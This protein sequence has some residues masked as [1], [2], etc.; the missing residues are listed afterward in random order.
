MLIRLREISKNFGAVQALKGVSLDLH[1]GEILAVVGENGA[2]KSTLMKILGG[3]YPHGDFQGQIEND[4][5]SFQFKSPRDSEAAGIAFIHQELSNFPD[6]TV[7]EN[8]VVGHWPAQAGFVKNDQIYQYADTWLQKLGAEFSSRQKMSELSTGQQQ[9]VEIAKALSRNSKIL[10]LDEPTSSLTSRETVKLFALLKELRGQGC[11]LIY[12]SHRMEEIFALADRVAI[13]RDGQSVFTAS[14]KELDEQKIVHHMVGRNLEHFFPERTEPVPSKV[15]LRIENFKARHKSSDL[16][17]GPLS[18]YVREGEILGFSGLLG[19]GRSELL[20]A[21]AGDK[22]Y[23]TKGEI[24]YLGSEKRWQE[25]RQSYADGMGLVPEDRKQQSLLTSRSLKENAGIVRLAQ[26]GLIS[27]ISDNDEVKRTLEELKILKTKFHNEDQKITE[28]SGGNQQ[29]VIFS[30]V[31]QNM[32]QVLILDEPTRGV[33]VGAKAE[34]YHLIRQWASQGKSILLISSDLPELMAMSD[35]VIV[36]SEGQMQ[37]ELS[38]DEI[39][40][41]TIMKWALGKGTKNE[42][43]SPH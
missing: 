2:G 43:V 7:A 39:Q 25:L 14:I 33:D 38:K 8:M 22:A 15:V 42:T 16:W 20:Q 6:L 23:E 21:L 30:R 41:E 27:W 3:V 28:L 40:E 29:K 31:L 5:Q 10:I 4:S 9:V 26:K 11:G 34:I 37:K 19:A 1:P 17:R 12:I 36:L 35:R 32:P 13:F 18:F 24:K